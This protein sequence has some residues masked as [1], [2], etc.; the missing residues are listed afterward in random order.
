MLLLTVRYHTLYFVHI[1]V[2]IRWWIG[3]KTKYTHSVLIA[4][5]CVVNHTTQ[6]DIL[7]FLNKKGD[8][9]LQ[10]IIF[11]KMKRDY[12]QSS[13]AAFQKSDA[14]VQCWSSEYIRSY[15]CYSDQAYAMF[16]RPFVPVFMI[17]LEDQST[18]LWALKTMPHCERILKLIFQMQLHQK[19][20]NWLLN[21]VPRISRLCSQC[22]PY[23]F[24]RSC[25]NQW[26]NWKSVASN[27]RQ[28]LST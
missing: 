5:K 8:L 9:M 27:R 2:A 28:R 16:V 25:S 14:V 24:R 19:R 20:C 10:L 12:F 21:L 6:T 23:N 1:V 15:Y 11:G 17:F 26:L 18:V 13:I 22:I 3:L 7:H 4:M